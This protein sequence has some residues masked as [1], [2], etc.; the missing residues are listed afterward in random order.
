MHERWAWHGAGSEALRK[1]HVVS[2]KTLN[3][4]CLSS[5]LR[6]P[7]R[8]ALTS[9][10]YIPPRTVPRRPLLCAHPSPSSQITFSHARYPRY[11][12]RTHLFIQHNRIGR[13]INN[14]INS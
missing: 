6:P 5:L 2:N 7:R 13:C 14:I 4:Q 12:S 11:S 1:Q 3:A 10:I 8:S 9:L